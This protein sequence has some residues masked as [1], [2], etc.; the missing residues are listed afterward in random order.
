MTLKDLLKKKEKIHD[1]V[2]A[3]IVPALEQD[4][5]APEF[6]IMRSDTNTQELISP[7]TFASDNAAAHTDDHSP[8]KRFSRL[9]TSSNASTT[10]KRSSIGE[11]RLSQRL[12][13]PH[14]RSRASSQSS[15]NVPS[16]L[17]DIQDLSLEGEEKE[18]RWE[19]RAT[20]LAQANPN[21]RPKSQDGRAESK[22]P[23][24]QLKERLQG[25]SP[26]HLSERPVMGSRSLSSATADDDIQKAIQLHEAG[27]LAQSTAMFGRLANG[28]AM[29]EIMYGLALRHGWGITPDPALAVQY[30]S[31]AA[32]SAALVESAA[33]SSGMKKGGAAKGELVLAIYELANS[34]RHGWGVEKDPIAARNYYETAANLG[35]TDAMNEVA[36]CYE[37]GDGGKKD[38]VSS[39][40]T[41][42]S[43]IKASRKP[44][45]RCY[46]RQSES[47][48]FN[49][50]LKKSSFTG[51]KKSVYNA[52]ASEHLLSPISIPQTQSQPSASSHS[53]S[54][55]Q[56]SMHL[57]NT[58]VKPIVHGS[59]I[60]P[61]RRTKWE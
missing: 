18:A 44:N 12:H 48:S 10:S 50:Q 54:S 36:R 40:N 47:L 21:S 1:N 55:H 31:A 15:V 13:L 45:R 58:L 49:I 30:L 35:D 51:H 38:R 19:E 8:S 20:I 39:E 2:I 25:H 53:N 17:P 52:S 46:P 26:A 24:E 9:R 29:A 5:S 11:K 14:S 33:L 7:P 60:L 4:A 37:M 41:I 23:D 22:S 32:A 34:F 59:A 6:T 16:D 56:A 43:T 61:P 57:A 27:D 42:P 28:N 3:P